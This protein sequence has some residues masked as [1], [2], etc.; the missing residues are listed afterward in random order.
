MSVAL[1]GSSGGGAATLGHTEPVQLLQ[2]IHKELRKVDGG[3]GIQIALFVAMQGGKGL[4]TANEK[5]DTATL[6]AIPFTEYP[7]E[8]CHVQVVMNGTLRAVNEAIRKMDATIA[9]AI[10]ENKIQGLICISCHVDLHSDTLKTA[11]S[12]GIPVTGSGGTSL[13]AAATNFGVVLVGNAG[14]SVATTSYTRAVSYTSALASSWSRLYKPFESAL[15]TPQWRSVLNACLPAF[16]G[17]ALLSRASDI[18]FEYLPTPIAHTAQHQA[19]DILRSRALPLVCCVVMATST[20]PQH[21]STVVMAAC[22]AGIF[23]ANSILAGMLAGWIISVFV[24]QVLYT[25]VRLGIPA[26]MTNLIASGGVGVG[27]A[28]MMAPFLSFLPVISQ[29]IRYCVHISMNGRVQGLGFVIG[30]LFCYGSKVGYYHAIGL[31]IILIEME[32][33]K[34]SLV[35]AIDEC[36][37]VLVSAGICFGNILVPRNLDDTNLAHCMRGLRINLFCGDFI[38]AAYP[39]ME[40]SAIINV[41]GY[42]ASGVSTE[43]L[44]GFRTQD[45]LSMAYL[46]VPL[47]IWLAR[48]W[49]RICLAYSAAF[50]ISFLGTITSNAMTP[51]RTIR[52]VD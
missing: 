43:L 7:N 11:A 41:A 15:T 18:Y 1:I 16:W 51:K 36:T 21:G 14:G 28:T 8:E 19:L 12:K 4:D 29:Y 24:G 38:E 46:P 37:L 9:S 17:V 5:V 25:C 6:Y 31:P 22:I 47:S 52:K 3:N 39:F 23:C 30:C 34:A 44:T 40:R 35:G 32:Q 2:A 26:T 49:R 10:R 27:V 48:D 33:G 20:A 50:I 42:L 45:V 13:S